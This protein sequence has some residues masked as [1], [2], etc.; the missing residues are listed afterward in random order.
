MLGYISATAGDRFVVSGNLISSS[1]QNTAWS[2]GLAELHFDTGGS[3]LLSVNGNDM[4]M[5][6]AGFIDNFAWDTL[7]LGGNQQLVLEDGNAGEY[8]TV[9][10]MCI[11]CC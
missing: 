9:L 8:R 7:E 11:N 10:Y 5:N 2:T 4:G 1:T 3:H 6:A